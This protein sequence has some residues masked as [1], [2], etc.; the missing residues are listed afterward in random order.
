MKLNILF[1]LY[2]AKTNSAGKCPIRCRITYNSKRK[3]FST[4]LF[5]SPKNWL[6]KQ[7]AIKPEEPDANLIETQLSLIKTKLSQAFLFLQVRGSDFN[8]DD[9]YKQYKGE[10]PKKEF[11]VMEVYNLHS[12]RIKKLVGI[13]IKEVTYSKY[14]ESGRHLK[15]FIKFKFRANDI[16]LKALKSSFLDHYEYYLKTEKKFQQS[17]LNK[18]IQRFRKVIKYA[19][20][21]D[22]LDKDP[23]ILYR[24]KR[25]KKEVLFLSPKQLQKLEQTSF[26]IKRIQHIKDM[27]VFCCYT[28]LGFTEMKQ[29]KKQDIVLGFDGELWINVRRAK[30]NRNYKVP[31]LPKAQE[32]KEVYDDIGS[33]YVFPS[34]SNPNFN[35]YLKEIAD[36]VGIEF[37][38][39]HHIAR[40]TFASTVLLYNNIPIEIVSKLLGHSKIQTTQDSYSKVVE[41]RISIEMKNLRG[42]Y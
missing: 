38:L 16:Q 35:A 7:Q 12:A 5:I 15:S 26:K 27:F 29:L 25:V 11:G 34:I 8:V 40:K 1:L 36:V 14:I 10:M 18:A 13:D 22:Y 41:K 23:F 28:G 24:A 21:E 4:G 2:K 9:I 3:Q 17:T 31:L 32:I 33:E 30:T 20:S 39:T 37:N 42:S 19:I 6:S